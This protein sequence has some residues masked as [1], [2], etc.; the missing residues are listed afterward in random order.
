[1]LQQSYTEKKMVYALTENSGLPTMAQ[2]HEDIARN[3]TGVTT[4]G[5]ALPET[6]HTSGSPIDH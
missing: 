6:H 4:E 3:I 2:V 5:C 1:M